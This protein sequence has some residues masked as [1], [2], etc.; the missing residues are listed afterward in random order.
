MP[1]HWYSFEIYSYNVSMHNAMLAL[2]KL[3][4]AIMHYVSTNF[5]WLDIES[6]IWNLCSNLQFFLKLDLL[7]PLIGFCQ[8]EPNI[9]DCL[10]ISALKG[11]VFVR[12]MSIH[13]YI[14]NLYERVFGEQV[15]RNYYLF[16]VDPSSMLWH[17]KRFDPKT[18]KK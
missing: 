5:H 4:Q 8:T 2:Q 1:L 3:F 16:H 11:S 15:I 6:F 12:V 10:R 18:R 14:Y 9:F 7:E 17:V 13:I